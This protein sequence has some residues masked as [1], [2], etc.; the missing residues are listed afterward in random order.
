MSQE[1]LMRGGK[2]KI[3]IPKR[4]VKHSPQDENEISENIEVGD[5]IKKAFE[6]RQRT[7]QKS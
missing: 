3:A 2:P 5:K 1:I 7:W 6:E 4:R